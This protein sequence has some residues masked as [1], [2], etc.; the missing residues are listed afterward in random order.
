M[1]SD[2]RGETQT[3]YQVLV[4]SAV[5]LLASD[6]GD[7]WDSGKVAS[8]A[9]AQVEYAGHALASRSECW[10]KVRIWDRDGNTSAW[11]Q[12]ASWNMGLLHAADWRTQWISDAI[13]ADPANRPMTPI[14]CYRSELCPTDGHH[15]GDD[16]DSSSPPARNESVIG[17]FGVHFP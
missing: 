13:L 3:A 15:G 14:H 9:T 1:A 16:H 7:L 6:K 8:A 11:S 5:A 2:R 4:A 17:A 10:W 12:P